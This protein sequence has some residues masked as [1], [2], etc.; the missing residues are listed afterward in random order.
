M[1]S[2]SSQPP[3][4]TQGYR[5]RDAQCMAEHVQYIETTMT[6]KDLIYVVEDD[7]KK[8]C[9]NRACPEQTK[10]IAIIT[11]EPLLN[12]GTLTEAH[13]VFIDPGAVPSFRRNGFLMDDPVWTQYVKKLIPKELR[14]YCTDCL[15]ELYKRCKEAWEVIDEL[16]YKRAHA[17]LPML[18]MPPILR[19]KSN[20][21]MYDQ[22]DSSSPDT[23]DESSLVHRLLSIDGLNIVTQNATGRTAED[24]LKGSS[25]KGKEPLRPQHFSE[26]DDTSRNNDF[27]SAQLAVRTNYIAVSLPN[28]NSFLQTPLPNRQ[29]PTTACVNH[30]ASATHEKNTQEED[31]KK[32]GSSATK[33]SIPD[34]SSLKRGEGC[35]IN[36]LAFC[37]YVKSCIE[38]RLTKKMLRI[39]GEVGEFATDVNEAGPSTPKRNA[40]TS[41]ANG[42]SGLG[43][44]P[45]NL[46]NQD[47]HPLIPFDGNGEAS[48]RAH[49][50]SSPLSNVPSDLSNRTTPEQ[51]SSPPKPSPKPQ[52]H[53]AP[54]FRRAPATQN[55]APGVSEQEYLA[56][57][58][59]VPN[60]DDIICICHKPA[61]TN[62]VRIVQCNTPDCPIG[63]LHYKCGD[64]NF[65]RSVRWRTQVCEI[66]KNEK[67]FANNLAAGGSTAPQTPPPF[68]GEDIIAVVVPNIGGF[69]ASRNPYGLAGNSGAVNGKPTPPLSPLAQSFI[70]ALCATQASGSDT[71]PAVGSAMAMGLAPSRPALFTEAYTNGTQLA[72][73]ADE[74]WADERCA[75]LAAEVGAAGCEDEWDDWDGEM[76]VSGQYEDEYEVGS[77]DV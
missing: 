58:T 55:P 56:S 26:V 28:S 40:S 38:K 77:G 45:P 15:G 66:C 20:A 53:L 13:D 7:S 47:L 59:R 17:R 27:T 44:V 29:S 31:Y 18:L 3:A 4:T 32:L 72:L 8:I 39:L 75:R 65:K 49:S 41:P 1:G 10:R 60:K 51:G 50:N 6:V 9:S 57:L 70:P 33:G 71:Q 5:W 2:N 21:Q 22:R 61:Q 54:V 62:E 64:A 74:R 68:T 46:S 25:V 24:S 23:H 37:S 69:T 52:P 14:S 35:D 48:I 36:T 42:S 67:H 11:V 12:W 76:D 16:T 43:S 63:W 34:F 19:P 73:E 30:T